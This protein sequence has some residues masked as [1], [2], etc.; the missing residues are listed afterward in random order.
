MI[1]CRLSSNTL[2]AYTIVPAASA[3][4]TTPN[5]LPTSGLLVECFAEL[6][7][8]IAN[9]P[10]K[11]ATRSQLRSVRSAARYTLGSI[12]LGGLHSGS[13]QTGSVRTP[14]ESLAE[15]EAHVAALLCWTVP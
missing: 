15:I 9:V 3:M 6:T 10:S 11:T 7:K 5:T 12:L 14:L 4:Y 2:Q 1:L 13:T 8:A